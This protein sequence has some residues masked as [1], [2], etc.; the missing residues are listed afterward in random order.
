CVPAGSWPPPGT[1]SEIAMVPPMVSVPGCTDST[2]LLPAGSSQKE[3]AV[4]MP[5]R[6]WLPTLA[7]GRIG[8]AIV[9]MGLSA[10]SPNVP[11]GD[12]A[13]ILIPELLMTA[14]PAVTPKESLSAM[15][16]T[17]PLGPDGNVGRVLEFPIGFGSVS[18]S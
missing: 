11:V 15:P 10:P 3:L 14:T 9:N 5:I 4:S 18:L 12:A 17:G 6:N 13:V 1:T 7:S 8:A 2:Y 16:R